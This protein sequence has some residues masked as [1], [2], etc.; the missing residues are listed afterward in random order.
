[1]EFILLVIGVVIGFLLDR[2]YDTI[3]PRMRLRRLKHILPI[4]ELSDNNELYIRPS[5]EILA[6]GAGEK[7]KR[8]YTHS[9]ETIA[10]QTL[11]AEVH[12]LPIKLIFDYSDRKIGDNQGLILLG[13]SREKSKLPSQVLDRIASSTG[14][15]IE[16][17]VDSHQF[18]R[19]SEGNEYHCEHLKD[20]KYETKV[21]KDFGI[22]YRGTSETG[23]PLV[24]LWRNSHV[25]NASCCGGGAL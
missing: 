19:D 14:I 11:S 21:V 24:N 17:P 9:C 20:P 6:L 12:A 16:K 7:S 18:F 5:L 25:W 10:L 1:M 13:L 4:T 23:S 3:A 22:I 8:G 2:A 15:I